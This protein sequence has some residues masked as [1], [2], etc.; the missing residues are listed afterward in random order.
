MAPNDEFI[1]EVDDE[2]RR[3]RVA[4]IWKRYNGLIIGGVL[5]MLALVGGWRYW[6]HMQ[7]TARAGSRRPLR[8][9]AAAVPRRKERRGETGLR[10]AREG[11]R[12]TATRLL[13]RFRLAAELGQSN[14]EDGATAYDASRSRHEIVSA[15]AG[16]RA[17]TRRLAASRHARSH[18][19]FARRSSGWPCRQIPGAIP[20]ASFSACRA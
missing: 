12:R 17:A 13:A 3:D 5:V 7:E 6:E 4:Q 11:G 2:Y 14:A 15:L 8:G 1:R 16:S 19:W 10:S 9:S 20:H 18:L